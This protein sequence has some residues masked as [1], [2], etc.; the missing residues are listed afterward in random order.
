MKDNNT[1]K[2]NDRRAGFTLV[3]ILLV[4]AIIGILASVV[5]VSFG[6]RAE[7][8]KIKAT[9]GSIMSI[10]TAVDLYEVEQG[11]YPSTLDDLTVAVEGQTPYLRGGVPVDSWGT[12]FS[13]ENKGGGVYV[14][15]SAGPDAQLG[16]EDDISSFTNE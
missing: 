4:V 6:G 10:C 2:R 16:T 5:V 14:V 1:N 15:K 11:K 13:Y 9:R 12:L 7:G 3:E 8:A